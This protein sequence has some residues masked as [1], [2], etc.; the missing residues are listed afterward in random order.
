M[1]DLGFSGVFL[2]MQLMDAHMAGGAIRPEQVH[3]A[4]LADR[5]VKLGDLVTLGQVGVEVILAVE[6]GTGIDLSVHDGCQQRAF[7]HRF[8]VQDRQYARKPTAH[9]AN[10][11]VR[12][13]APGIGF[14]GAENLGF[15][16]Q[17]DMGFEPDD[18]FI[19]FHHATSPRNTWGRS[20]RHAASWVACSKALA[21]RRIRSSR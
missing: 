14:A 17:L 1:V 4:T 5:L 9:R 18:H 6:E 12:F 8:R 3:I 20:A 16:I 10:V 13:R 15:G 2:K 19:R 11:S 7:F 21:T